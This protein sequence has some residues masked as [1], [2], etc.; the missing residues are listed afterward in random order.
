MALRLRKKAAK[1]LSILKLARKQIKE[2]P[3]RNTPLGQPDGGVCGDG[4]SKS[5]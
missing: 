1:R 2:P 5:F 3:V 4:T